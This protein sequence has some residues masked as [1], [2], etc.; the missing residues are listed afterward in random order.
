MNLVEEI[1]L[2]TP[3]DNSL[4]YL[5]LAQPESINS[6]NLAMIKKLQSSHCIPLLVTVNQPFKILSKI[7]KAGG[8]DP[9]SV[10]VVDAVTLYSGGNTGP[11]PK[12]RYVNNPANLTDLGIAI[13]EILK[14]MP[15]GKKCILFDSVSMLLIHIPSVSAAKFLHF[16]INKLKLSDVSGIFL[17][18]EKGVDPV[19]IAQMSASVDKIVDFESG[20]TGD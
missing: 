10:Y 9:E 13:T 7:Y 11:N 20:K 17:C 1:D 14:I 18:V 19:V 8:I 3:D 5:L 12:V 6:M 15:E 2:H 16:V 4:L